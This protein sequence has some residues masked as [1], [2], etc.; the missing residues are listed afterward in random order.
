LDEWIVMPNHVHAIIR[1]DAGFVGAV[2]EP[3]VDGREK[4]IKPLGELVGA[5]KT[6]SS[7]KINQMR[8][9]PGEIF[10]QRNYYEHVIRGENELERIRNY[11]YFNPQAWPSDPENPRG[12]GG[13]TR[14]GTGGSRTAPT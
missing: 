3:P 12:P 8:G 10:W 1:I 14:R 11:I 4:K 9:T 2:R 6:V 7:K 5:F 13:T